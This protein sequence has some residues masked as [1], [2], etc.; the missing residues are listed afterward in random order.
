M[1]LIIPNEM[2]I[3]SQPTVAITFGRTQSEF[4]SRLKYW[5]NRATKYREGKLWVWKT[6]ED[7]AV[8]LNKSTKTIGRI[9]DELEERGVIESKKFESKDWYQGKSYRI[10]IDR[11]YEILGIPVPK[12]P[13]VD[14]KRQDVQELEQDV[15]IITHNTP[16]VISPVCI[17]QIKKEDEFWNQEEDWALIKALGD[18]KIDPE[19]N[20]GITFA[21]IA[22]KVKA[23][24]DQLR[25]ALAECFD[26]KFYVKNPFGF[27]SKLLKDY[28]SGEKAYF[29]YHYS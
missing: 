19:S 1:D 4:L 8:E 23:N 17:E 10:N 16:I 22:K 12:D 25:Q 5:M 11:L 15:P 6:V 27:V 21:K 28:I 24:A 29:S 14:K 9:I 18:S 26:A 3:V 7:W 20:A 2:P 13:L